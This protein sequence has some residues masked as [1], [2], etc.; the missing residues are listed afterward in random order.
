MATGYLQQKYPHNSNSKW[1]LF[2]NFISNLLISYVNFNQIERKLKNKQQSAVT[3]INLI[4]RYKLLLQISYL[5]ELSHEWINQ[6]V[7]HT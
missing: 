2:H 6:T 7:V 1:Y 4:L 3:A 5:I